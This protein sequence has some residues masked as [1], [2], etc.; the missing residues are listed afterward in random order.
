MSTPIDLPRQLVN[1]VS[2]R[3][4]LLAGREIPNAKVGAEAIAEIDAPGPVDIDPVGAV[5]SGRGA[6]VNDQLEGAALPGAPFYT[7]GEAAAL[8]DD[9]VA[10]GEG[11]VG[12]ELDGVGEGDDGGGGRGGVD[13]GGG[14]Q[15][16]QGYGEE[17]G[18][19]HGGWF[20]W[21]GCWCWCWCWMVG[22]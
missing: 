8:L 2:L 15:C 3:K 5:G 12:G 21:V 18:G 4:R 20:V 6:N 19:V 13:G 14:G 17:A 16:G 1:A 22:E 9:A 7:A 10:R 11:G